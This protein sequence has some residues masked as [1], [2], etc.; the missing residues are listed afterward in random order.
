MKSVVRLVLISFFVNNLSDDKEMLTKGS[1]QRIRFMVGL[2]WK[3]R[4]QEG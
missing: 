3:R 2:R 1:L 4:E